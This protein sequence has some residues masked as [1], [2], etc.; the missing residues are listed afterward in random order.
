[1]NDAAKSSQ[2]ITVRILDKP[3]ASALPVNHEKFIKVAL[4]GVGGLLGGFLLALTAEVF[5]RT[6]RFKKD[7]IEEFE[8]EVVG[9]LPE[10]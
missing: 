5:C 6:V 3:T 9:V 2:T 4:G 1:M 7:V 8:L 10:K